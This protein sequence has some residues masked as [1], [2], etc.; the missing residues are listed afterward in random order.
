MCPASSVT[1]VSAAAPL[2]G[3]YAADGSVANVRSTTGTVTV[4]K[5]VAAFPTM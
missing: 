2:D 1:D 4:V 3:G 5:R